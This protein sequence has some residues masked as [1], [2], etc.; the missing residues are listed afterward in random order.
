ME[1]K[2]L[3]II[4]AAGYGRRMG[5]IDRPKVMLPDCNGRPLVEDAFTFLNYR[6]QNLD[7]AVLSRQESFFEPL[8]EYL[9]NHPR[10]GEFSV[11]YQHVKPTEFHRYGAYYGISQIWQN[12]PCA[13]AIQQHYCFAGRP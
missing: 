1:E 2:N 7:F 3:A 12:L 5:K 11:L 8:N 6:T 10:S 13:P 9:R 4:T